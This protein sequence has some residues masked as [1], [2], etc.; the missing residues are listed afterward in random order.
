MFFGRF[1]QPTFWDRFWTVTWDSFGNVLVSIDRFLR[2]LEQF[3]DGFCQFV[4]V[5][6]KRLRTVCGHFFASFGQYWYLISS[7]RTV[8]RQ[9]LAVLRHFLNIWLDSS[10]LLA[11]F[12]DDFQLRWSKTIL[13][14]FCQIETCKRYENSF[15]VD[16]YFAV[17]QLSSNYFTFPLESHTHPLYNAPFRQIVHS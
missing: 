3:Q 4:K 1:L 6:F 8:S 13:I 16:R 12:Q 2:I 11:S 5:F 15:N 17:V 7:F 9:F 14:K 10:K